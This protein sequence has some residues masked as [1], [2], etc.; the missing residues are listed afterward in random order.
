MP[1]WYARW[2]ECVLPYVMVGRRQWEGALELCV[3]ALAQARAAGDLSG[4]ADVLYC[5]AVLARETGRLAD[6]GAHLRESAAIAANGPYRL[7][8][9]DCLD[10]GGHWC[11]ATGQY[12][13]AISPWQQVVFH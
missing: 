5:M 4:Q 8:L 10:E 9:V 11:A 3:N 13:A 6:A 7:R 12:A 2:V 1:G